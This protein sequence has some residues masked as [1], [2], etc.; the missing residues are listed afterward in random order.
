MAIFLKELFLLTLVSSGLTFPLQPLGK[1]KYDIS[2]KTA[3]FFI[4]Y[5]AM[6]S[7]RNLLFYPEWQEWQVLFYCNNKLSF[8][9]LYAVRVF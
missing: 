8:V 3:Y 7:S 2:Y 4:R 6:F 5:H 9:S 1:L